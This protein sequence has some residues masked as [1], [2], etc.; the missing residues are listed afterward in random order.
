MNLHPAPSYHD[1][2]VLGQLE[3]YG[4]TQMA[5]GDNVLH[6][7]RGSRDAWALARAAAEPKTKK[8]PQLSCRA[9]LKP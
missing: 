2:N 5:E 1:D 6:A 9:R 7:S 3:S 8:K 4:S